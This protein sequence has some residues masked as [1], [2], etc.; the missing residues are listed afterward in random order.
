MT[1][2]GHAVIG[3]VIAA[4]IPN[5][6]IAAPL[7]ILSH[8]AADVFPHWDVGTHEKTKSRKL[9]MQQAFIDVLFGF[10]ISYLLIIFVF[11]NT[12]LLYAF[13]M[14]ILA[15]GFDWAWAPY[16]FFH[17]KKFPVFKWIFDF[18][19]HFDNR[20]GKPWGIINQIAVLVLLVI[21][22]KIYLSSL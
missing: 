15:Q 9:I 3:T 5:P 18:S 7:A 21:I 17:I 19:I 2:T 11:P 10:I 8:L 4:T 6:W 14:I 12:N 20:L 22:A 16:Y 1:A 13:I